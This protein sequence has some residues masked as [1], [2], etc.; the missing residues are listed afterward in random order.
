MPEAAHRQVSGDI[1]LLEASDHGTVEVK[2]QVVRASTALRSDI[3]RMIH[4]LHNMWKL[5]DVCHEQ[6]TQ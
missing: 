4:L 1:L 5:L 6:V 2:L 3:L